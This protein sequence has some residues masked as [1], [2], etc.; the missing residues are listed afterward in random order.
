MRRDIDKDPILHPTTREQ[1]IPAIS[2]P[3]SFGLESWRRN[4]D[5]QCEG[6][7][8]CEYPHKLTSLPSC[9]SFSIPESV[10]T[11]TLE[12]SAQRPIDFWTVRVGS[13]VWFGDL[14]TTSGVFWLFAQETQKN[15]TQVTRCHHDVVRS[16]GRR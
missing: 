11:Y 10:S 12:D 16:Y 5:L 14:N 1:S 2:Y 4:L 8:K 7:G 15:D 3:L 13:C 6:Q 9:A